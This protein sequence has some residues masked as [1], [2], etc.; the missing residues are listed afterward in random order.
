MPK[1]DL[2]ILEFAD[3]AAWERWLHDH[4]DSARGVWLKIAKKSAPAQ[5]VNYAEALE[6]ALCFGWIDGQRAASTRSSSSSGSPRGASAA[7]GHRSTA[8][9]AHGLI[10]AE[11]M[12]P[13]G[14]R[15]VRGRP[16]R[17]TLGRRP[18]SPRARPRSRPTSRPRS[19][20]N[21]KAAEFFATLKGNNRY[22]FLYRLHNVKRPDA[23]AKR[24][25]T[26][27]EML[28]ARKTF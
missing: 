22:A 17:R 9:P 13:A 15:G 24:I 26:Y 5:T 6:E 28:N 18:T 4:H 2:P 27:I 19:T 11:R 14:L 1:D 20:Q 8:P 10:E 21:P 12:R 3:Q 25:A 16:R 7:S 23:R